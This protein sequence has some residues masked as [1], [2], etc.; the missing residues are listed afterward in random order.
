MFKRSNSLF[1]FVFISLI[2][3]LALSGCFDDVGGSSTS[4]P[5]GNSG[6]SGGSG[7]SVLGFGG[8]DYSYSCPASGPASAPIPPTVSS[9]CERI[10]ERTASEIGCNIVDDYDYLI[11]EYQSCIDQEVAACSSASTGDPNC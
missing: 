3:A 6:S 7:G 5:S 1:S 4:A 9:F 8:Y 10:Y 2:S 11:S